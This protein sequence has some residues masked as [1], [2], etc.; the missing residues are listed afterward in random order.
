MQ[1]SFALLESSEGGKHGDLCNFDGLLGIEEL[2]VQML[3]ILFD[4]HD[5]ARNEVVTTCLSK[6]YL[7]SSVFSP[8]LL[9]IFF[10]QA[11]LM[12]I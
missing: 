9:L 6:C 8:P 12:L 10:W 4:I 11:P 3:K 1:F 7:L 5:M 2:S